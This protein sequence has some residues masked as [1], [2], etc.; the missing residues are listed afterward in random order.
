[1]YKILNE[2]VAVPMNHLYLVLCDRPVRG[3]TTKQRLN[4]PHCASTPFQ[5]SFAARTEKNILEKNDNAKWNNSCRS[6]YYWVEFIT[7]LHHL[8]GH[9]TIRQKT[10]VCYIVPIGVNTS[11]HNIHQEFNN[12]HPDPEYITL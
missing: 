5:K 9:S 2:H 8:V 12:Y 1:V 7:R 6:N 10:A 3:P 11:L 4:I